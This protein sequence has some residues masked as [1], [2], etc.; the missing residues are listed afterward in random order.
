MRQVASDQVRVQVSFRRMDA[1]LTSVADR[2]ALLPL[3]STSSK[4]P[5]TNRAEPDSTAGSI[6]VAWVSS[7]AM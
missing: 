1:S 3:P 7:T 5:S 6:G 2:E 4:S